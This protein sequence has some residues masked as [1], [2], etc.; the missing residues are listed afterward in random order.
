MKKKILY[1][2][3]GAGLGNCTRMLAILDGLGREG[4]DIAIMAPSRILR[5][6]P[7]SFGAYALEDVTYGAE[8]FSALNVLRSNLTLPQKLRENY[9][10]CGRVLDEVGPDA[11]VVDSDFHCLPLARKRKVP[12]ISVNSTF[13]TVHLFRQLRG[14]RSQMLFS[15]YCIER[16]DLWLQK[17]YAD[18]IVCPVIEP[19]EIDCAKLRQVNPIVRRQFLDARPDP[20]GNGEEYDVAVMPGGSGIGVADM[21]LSGFSGKVVVLGTTRGLKTRPGAKVLGF[22]PEP[23]KHLARARIL[24]VQGGLNSV[25]EAIALRK[26]AVL[27]PIRNHAEQFVNARCAE[28]LG[29]A[30]IAWDGNVVEAI[31]G[32]DANYDNYLRACRALAP[33]CDGAEQAARL[34]RDFIHG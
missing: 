9:R 16:V 7:P 8:G 28:R 10:R 11:L 2:I 13:A 23:A 30:R 3:A 33:R 12:V 4:L 32:M 27:I 14:S 25:S 22:D 19:V 24:V 29:I 17:R 21:D 34:I 6:I 15:Y 18:L 5:R 31:R 1:V 26:P 20:A